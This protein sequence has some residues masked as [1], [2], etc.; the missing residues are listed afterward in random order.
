MKDSK[1]IEQYVINLLNGDGNIIEEDKYIIASNK[2]YEHIKTLNLDGYE[3]PCKPR[4]KTTPEYSS[5]TEP[6]TDILF[7]S[8]NEKYKCSLK[9]DDGAY[10]VSCNSQEDFIKQIIEI[11]NGREI[12]GPDMIEM[13]EKSSSYI[14][15]VPNFNNFDPYYKKEGRTVDDFVMEKFYPRSKKYI[16]HEKSLEFAKFIISCYKNDILAKEYTEYLHEAESFIQNTMRKL[17]TEYPDYAKK[18]IFEFITGK[19]KFKDV[20]NENCSCDY[21]VSTDGMFILDNYNCLYVNHMYNKFMKSPHIGRLQNVPRKNVTKKR[22]L[23]GDMI[24]VANDFSVADLTFK[25]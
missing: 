4:V 3:K 20:K 14:N 9:L 15:K 13:I 24:S 12:L 11:H 18:I 22:L 17:F 10:M 5:K 7:Y 23:N 1:H 2:I 21:L 6:K 16:G 8:S 19:I 25:L